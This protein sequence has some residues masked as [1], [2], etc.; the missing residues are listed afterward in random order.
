MKKT[1]DDDAREWTAKDFKKAKRLKDEHPDI[2]KALKR[3]PGRPAL[4]NPKQEV[5]IRLDADVL[6]WLKAEGRGYQT[7]LNAILRE[8]MGR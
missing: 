4:A 8:A 6:A 3:G 5:K 2:V 1:H 7:R